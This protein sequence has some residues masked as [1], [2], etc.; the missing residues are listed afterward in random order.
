[1]LTQTKIQIA[2]PLVPVINITI[3]KLYPVVARKLDRFGVSKRVGAAIMSTN[4]Q[5]VSLI[6]LTDT[7]HVVAHSKIRRIML[8][9]EIIE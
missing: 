3:T 6:T 7:T 2:L 8:K 5:D 4:F 9:I 1:M